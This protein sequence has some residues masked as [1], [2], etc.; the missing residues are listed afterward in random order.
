MSV[1]ISSAK[2]NLRE[3]SKNLLLLEDHLSDDDKWCEDCIRKHLLMV[4][5]LA[6]EVMTM[7]P[8]SI[9]IPHCK[10]ISV[11]ARNWMIMVAD[12]LDKSGIAKE[13]RKVRK[14]VVQHVFDPR[15]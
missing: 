3:I 13:V 8:S 9:W 7:A 11:L 5:A 1:G 10:R 15:G 14:D 12:G 6:E 2:F 4:E